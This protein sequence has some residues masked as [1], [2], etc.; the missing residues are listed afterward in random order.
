MLTFRPR[1]RNQARHRLPVHKNYDADMKKM[2]RGSET[3]TMTD[4]CSRRY[5][6]GDMEKGAYLK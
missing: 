6:I 5:P 3:A 4:P 2:A 1:T